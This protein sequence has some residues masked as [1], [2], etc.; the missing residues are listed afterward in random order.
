MADPRFYQLAG[1]FTVAEIAARVGAE[2]A[3]GADPARQIRDV[4]PLGEAAAEHLSF[5]ENRRYLTHFAE[6]RAGACIVEPAHRERAPTGMA[7]LLAPRPRRAYAL[8][9]AMFHPDPEL[10][11]GIHPRASVEPSAKLGADV[12]VEAGAVIGAHAEIGARA[13]ISANAVIGTGVVIG[14]DSVIGANASVSHA[15]IGDRV[16]IYPGARIGTTG[17]GFDPSPEGHRKIP[18]LGRVLI[19]DDVEVG[20]NSTVDRGSGPDT[21]I[22]RGCM[23]D[24]LV[25]I[26]H[27]VQLGE[28]CILVGQSGVAGSARLGRLV[29]LAAQAGISGHLEIGDG[30]VVGPQAGVKDD[31]A[32]GQTVLGAPAIPA[33]EFARQVAAL[34]LLAAKK[35][36]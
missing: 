34:K 25:Q 36:K 7:L 33:L 12:R 18:Q 30:A 5:L 29:T 14:A 26:G 20:A 10:E 2:L 35:G 4:A 6:S 8:A 23:I 32:A 9:A 17:F 24:N 21:V 27:N 16:V 19:G 13:Q 31:V 1:P 11:P 3:P 28:G 22:A 15:I